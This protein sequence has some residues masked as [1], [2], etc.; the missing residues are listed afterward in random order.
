VEYAIYNNS[1]RLFV[2]KYQLWLPDREELKAV[3]EKQLSEEAQI[4]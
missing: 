1:S 2:S 4:N 3:I